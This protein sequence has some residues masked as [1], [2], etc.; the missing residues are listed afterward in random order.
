MRRSL[1]HEN[2][3]PI[4]AKGEFDFGSVQ[5]FI[6]NNPEF[7]PNGAKVNKLGQTAIG[8]IGKTLSEGTIADT[9]YFMNTEQTLKASHLLYIDYLAPIGKGKEYVGA[10]LVGGWYTRNIRIFSNLHSDIRGQ[11]QDRDHL[12]SRT[13]S[14]Y[15]AVVG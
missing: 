4:D 2:I 1:S 3:Y 6:K 11:G 5:E 15:S 8:L 13:Y 7:A 12:R 10:N 9:L 14:D